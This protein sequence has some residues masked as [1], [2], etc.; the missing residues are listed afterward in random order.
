[1]AKRSDVGYRRPPKERQFKKGQSGNP[2]GRPKGTINL[3][4]ALTRTLS[5]TI[6][7]E[8]DGQKE[9][10]T[11]MEAAVRALV[12]EAL[13]GSMQAFRVLVVLNHLLQDPS[14]PPAGSELEAADQKILDMMVRR[15]STTSGE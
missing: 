14:S 11:K 10:I 6:E 9:T 1:M 12:D 3:A 13:T 15:F 7:V 4:T 5:Q 8:E 2:S